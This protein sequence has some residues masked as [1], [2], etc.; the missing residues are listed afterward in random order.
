MLKYILITV[1]IIILL[2]IAIYF[3]LS[4]EYNVGKLKDFLKLIYFK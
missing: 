1:L 3:Y 2:P 4:K